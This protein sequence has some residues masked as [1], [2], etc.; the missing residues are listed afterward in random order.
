MKRKLLT[1]GTAALFFI[2]ASFITSCGNSQN[3]DNQEEHE[4]IS[5]SDMEKDAVYA[6]PM[7]HEIT[8]NKGDNC[9]ECGMP[10]EKLEED[11]SNHNHE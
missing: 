11:H 9:T 4:H 6:C 1:Y 3:S 7:H 10:L 5:D 2:G 8:G